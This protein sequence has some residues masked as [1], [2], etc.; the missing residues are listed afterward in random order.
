MNNLNK[1]ILT[2][3]KIPDNLWDEFRI[4]CVKNKFSLQK[5]TE[6]SMY[7]YLT[8]EDFRTNLHN[9]LHTQLTGSI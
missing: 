7:L 3:V 8:D 4:N 9:I 6:R 1:K 2:S 5:L